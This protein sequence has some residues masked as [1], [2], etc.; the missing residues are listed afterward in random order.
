ME[1]STIRDKA[2]KA[3]VMELHKTNAA[4]NMAI[5]GSKGS[6]INISQMIACVGQQAI[7]GKRAPND[8][9][10]RS[11]P[12]FER[13][14]K[15]PA[16]KGFVS[17][18]FFSGITPTEF[19]FHAMAGR[20]GLVD[21]AVKT[22]ETGYMQRRLVKLLEDLYV[23]YDMTVRNSAQ[24]IIQ[25]RYG[26]D[27]LDPTQLEG[28]TGPVDLQRVLDHIR[29]KDLVQ[30]EEPLSGG[31]ILQLTEQYLAEDAFKVFS[32]E[33]KKDLMSFTKNLSKKV[34]KVYNTLLIPSRNTTLIVS[35]LQEHYLYC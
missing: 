11:L 27:G 6:F 14:S 4:L 26:G 21:T 29:A 20:E 5:S 18:S 35:T 19:V 24:D 22:S 33:F 7:S 10:D 15:I 2:G 31:Q 28:S 32:E 8:F 3:C 12:H 16:A 13:H 25:I 23:A 9:E 34:D 1:L 17:N 30:E